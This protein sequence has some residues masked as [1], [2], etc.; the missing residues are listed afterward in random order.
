MKRL[1]GILL[2]GGRGTRLA[3]ISSAINKHLLP[4]YDKPMFY[5]PLSTLML[6]GIREI[7]LISDPKDLSN[8]QKLLGDGSRLGIEISYFAQADPNGLPEAFTITEEFLDGDSSALI[9]GDNLLFGPGYGRSLQKKTIGEGA[10]IFACPVENPKDYGVIEINHIGAVTSL[11][12]KPLN[13]KSN[14][15]IPGFY[16]FDGKVS[17]YARSLKPSK[18][19]ELEIIDLL[20]IYLEL[21]QLEVEIANRGTSWLDAGTT[22]NLFTASELVKVTQN[23]QGYKVNVPEEIAFES[24]WITLAELE[25]TAQFYKNSPYGDYLFTVAKRAN[26]DFN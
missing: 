13:P 26:S 6:S 10:S 22:E 16:F 3:P 4:I 8:F 14:L 20:R 12:E 19:G 2:A 24:G 21:G 17:E 11:E 25:K 18:R 7:A 23:R 15:A 9:L 5:Y 1:K